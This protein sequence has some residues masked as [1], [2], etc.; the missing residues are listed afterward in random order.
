M[1]KRLNAQDSSIEN[2][3]DTVMYIHREDMRDRYTTLQN[4]ADIIVTKH[5]NG[6]REEISLYC[7]PSTG[8]FRDLMSNSEPES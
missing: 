3:A 8:R 4:I 2:D 1:R 6:I 5:R 7:E